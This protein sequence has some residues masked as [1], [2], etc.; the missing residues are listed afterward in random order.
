M[1]DRLYVPDDEMRNYYAYFGIVLVSYLLGGVI[2][3][4]GN[5]GV[6]F[7]QH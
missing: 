3:A 7:D 4:I 5:P 2:G 6:R 1:H